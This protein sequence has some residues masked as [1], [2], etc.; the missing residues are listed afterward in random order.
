MTSGCLSDTG[1]VVSAPGTSTVTSGA[2]SGTATIC[3]TGAGSSKLPP[4][5]GVTS[6]IQRALCR[7][8]R[9]PLK[10]FPSG[11]TETRRSGPR[12]ATRATG[13]V[14]WPRVTTRVP[15]GKGSGSSP[16][17]SGSSAR[18]KYAGYRARSCRSVSNI[19]R[20]TCTWTVSDERRRATTRRYRSLSSGPSTTVANPAVSRSS[21]RVVQGSP[22]DRTQS[23]AVRCPTAV[24]DAVTLSPRRTWIRSTES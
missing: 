18:S 6:R 8:T 16:E 15:T 1:A 5:S 22:G 3:R 4:P 11:V 10:V 9:T 20:A 17:V 12:Q 19:G 7:T 24:M 21:D 14:A 23:V 13:T 2:L